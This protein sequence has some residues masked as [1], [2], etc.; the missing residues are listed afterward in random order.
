MVE[1]N[2]FRV[3]LQ[4]LGFTASATII[5]RFCQ[6]AQGFPESESIR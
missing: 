5:S 4:G 2:S 1:Q 3:L 6:Q